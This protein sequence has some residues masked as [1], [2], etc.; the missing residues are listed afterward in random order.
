MVGKAEASNFA[1]GIEAIDLITNQKL[2]C[3]PVNL[4]SLSVDLQ[5]KPFE[6]RRDRFERGIG[7]LSHRISRTPSN[8]KNMRPHEFSSG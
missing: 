7:P 6:C 3:H 4:G 2:V 1:V 8:C 5:C